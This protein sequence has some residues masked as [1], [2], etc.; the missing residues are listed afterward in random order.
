MDSAIN[1]IKELTAILNQAAKAYYTDNK[2]IISNIEYDKLYD[3]LLCLE[4]EHGVV[5]SDS[6]TV[7]VGYEILESLPKEKHPNKMLS[8]DK[9][10]DINAIVSW[11]GD[12]EGVL[13]FKV[14]GITIVLTYDNGE[15]INA[16]TRGNGEIGEIVTSNAKMFKDVPLSIFEKEKL[17]VRGE[18]YIGYADFERINKKLDVEVEQYKNPRNLCSGSVRQL[19][20]KIT[21]E[22]NVSFLAF[23]MI[24]TKDG[25]KEKELIMLNEMGFKIVPY[26]KVNKINVEEKTKELTQSAK[27]SDIPTDGLVLS[28]NDIEYGVSLGVTSKFPRNAIAYK[29]EDETAKTILREIEWS[30]SRTGLINPVA[31]FDPVELESTTVTR[32]SVH[33]ISILKDLNLVVGDK[34]EVYKANMIIP[35]ISR[36]LKEKFCPENEIEIIEKCPICDENTVIKKEG[37][38]ETLLCPNVNCPA[39][40]IK[41]FVHFISRDA[42]NIEGISEAT[43]EKFIAEHIL[44]DLSSIYD[45]KYKQEVISSMEGFGS[46]SFNNMVN[47]IDKS[48]LVETHRF[49]YGLGIGG[50]GIANAKLISKRWKGIWQDIQNSAYEELVEIDGIGPV[51]ATNFVEYFRKK[52][53]LIEIEKLLNCITLIEEEDVDFD[54]MPLKDKVYVI[55]GSTAIF[56]NRNEMKNFIEKNG[57]KVSSSVSKNTDYLINNDKGSSSSKNKSATAL[58]IKIISEEE[59]INSING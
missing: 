39:K 11:I 43:I 25:E 27:V 13:S 48:K 58:G 23:E 41:E 26:E 36:N 34:I 50:I 53:N 55:T 56:S 14:D 3:E 7:N 20:T 6:P 19:N 12:K 49:L 10:K 5:L 37:A 51:M 38:V 57:G 16:V 35:Q 31:I 28:Y 8:L 30:P 54:N 18:A 33:N 59:L 22:R 45:V 15:L 2:E 21:K 29:W 4:K 42:M 1:R 47:A 32:A 17:I 46:K 9:T 40:K 24:G 52:S 44:E